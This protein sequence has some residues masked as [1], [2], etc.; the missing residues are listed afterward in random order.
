VEHPQTNGQAEAANKII[1]NGLKKR[2]K[3]AK[4]N[5]VEN[6]YQVLWSYRTTPHS[7]TGETPYRLVY[8]TNIMIPVE[9]GEPSLRVMHTS[10]NNNQLL[11]E[12]LDLVDETRELAQLT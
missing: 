10:P 9:I 11:S 4:G 3:D 6:L 5:W 12:K 7:T 8:G 1:L 2:L